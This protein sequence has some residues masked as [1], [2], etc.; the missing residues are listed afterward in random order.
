MFVVTYKNPVNG[1]AYFLRSTIWTSEGDR[2]QEFATKAAA[3][4]QLEKA[5]QFMKASV[6]RNAR[7][8]EA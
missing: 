1:Q 8:V 4:A 5:K 2:A 6:Y 3:E 7:V